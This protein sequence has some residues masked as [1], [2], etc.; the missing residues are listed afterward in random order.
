MAVD[1]D[2]LIAAVASMTYVQ[3][4]QL[5]MA[6]IGQAYSSTY[7]HWATTVKLVPNPDGA[8]IATTLPNVPPPSSLT[9]GLHVGDLIVFDDG[10]IV[11]ITGDHA[12]SATTPSSQ[13]SAF[14]LA[15]NGF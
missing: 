14:V 8:A 10:G 3:R 6:F 5:R 9:R 15:A 4:L 11:T 7:N 1:P 2:E 13:A 12:V